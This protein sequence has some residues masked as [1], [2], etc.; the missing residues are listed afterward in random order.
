MI[1]FIFNSW[2]EEKKTKE[3]RYSLFPQRER[4]DAGAHQGHFFF[5]FLE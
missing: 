4:Q 5:H 2:S 1:Q 3:A